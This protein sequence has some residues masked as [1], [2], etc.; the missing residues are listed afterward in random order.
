[1]KKIVSLFIGV[2]FATTM[3]ASENIKATLTVKSKIDEKVVICKVGADICYT[4]TQ[5]TSTC[6]PMNDNLPPPV[7]VTGYFIV[8]TNC[9]TGAYIASGITQTGN[10]CPPGSID[11]HSY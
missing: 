8:M 2:L 4:A 10:S 11:P 6:C 7:I 1:M 5:L 3:F 9:T